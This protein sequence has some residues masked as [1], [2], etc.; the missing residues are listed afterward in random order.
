MA[1]NEEYQVKEA[2]KAI[3]L[4]DDI[5]ARTLAS[6]EAKRKQ[7]ESERT[8]GLLA[9]Q[10]GIHA[11]KHAGQKDKATEESSDSP[12]AAMKSKHQ[13]GRGALLPRNAA[14]PCI[15]PKAGA[16]PRLQRA[17]RLSRVSSAARSISYDPW[18]M[19]ESK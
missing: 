9:A 5:A 6:I 3:H 19:W 12:A 13:K 8:A 16:S 10:E 15:S 2:I 11:N 14:R 18:R 17:W 1:N 4:S 7:Q